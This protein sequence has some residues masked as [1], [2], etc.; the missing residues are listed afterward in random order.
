M[1][2]RQELLALLGTADH[3]PLGAFGQ[4]GGRGRHARLGRE[5][6]PVV[7]HVA[8]HGVADVVRRK[9]ETINAKEN[10]AFVELVG[11]AQLVL[12]DLGERRALV[13]EVE[14]EGPA[15]HTSALDDVLDKQADE[16]FVGA[17]AWL[18]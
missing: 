11:E 3:H 4:L 9:R 1:S 12:E 7:E 10:L 2:Q 14:V 16:F 15:R 6:A 5:E 18:K 17:N 13:V 8:G